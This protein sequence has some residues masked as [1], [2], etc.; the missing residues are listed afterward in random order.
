MNLDEALAVLCACYLPRNPGGV[1]PVG[2][3]PDVPH[4]VWNIALD[5]A[6]ANAR[7]TAARYWAMDIEER[8]ALAQEGK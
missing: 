2:D 3:E 8:W 5:V 4:A 6:R 7:L 1:L